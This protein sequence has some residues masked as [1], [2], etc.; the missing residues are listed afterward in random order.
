MKSSKSYP[1]TVEADM[2]RMALEA[3]VSKPSAHRNDVPPGKLL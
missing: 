2:A 1:T 3:T